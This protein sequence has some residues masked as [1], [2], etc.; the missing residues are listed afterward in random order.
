MEVKPLPTK[1]DRN[2]MVIVM[3][4]YF[5]G[6]INDIESVFYALPVVK[7]DQPKPK[8]KVTKIKFV[9][10]GLSK[11][12]ISARYKD[13]V[14]GVVRAIT[15]AP[16][17]H[18]V[19]VDMSEHTKNISFKI[20]RC[21]LHMCGCKSV[22]MGVEASK[23][24]V[25]HINDAQAGI[26]L[27]QSNKEIADEIMREYTKECSYV[28]DGIMCFDISK[29]TFV[30][31]EDEIR[32]GVKKAIGNLLSDLSP[33]LSKGFHSKLSDAISKYKWALSV[34]PFIEEPLVYDH[35]VVGMVKYRFNLGFCVNLSSIIIFVKQMDQRFLPNYFS[36]VRNKAV[37]EFECLNDPESK[38]TF[39]VERSGQVTHS[40]K[41]LEEID[42]VFSIFIE[43]IGYIRK[44][45]EIEE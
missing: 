21:N 18:S 6:T 32:N 20:S 45:I 27:V 12:L 13:K 16:W 36:G 42:K 44:Y 28:S 31:E 39:S 19:V 37:F 30:E 10:P 8:R 35:F 3:I 40:C 9:H 14:R 17:K 15:K 5:K 43:I 23:M 25:D 26:S 38:H 22:E 34:E 4:S 41:V 7:T 11:V 29:F 24:M 1:E 33:D 2:V